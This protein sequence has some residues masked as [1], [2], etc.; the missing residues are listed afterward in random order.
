VAGRYKLAEQVVFRGAA[1][2]GFR[3]PS[4]QQS[5]YSATATNFING[6]PFEVKTAPV[7][8][9]VAR[10]LGSRPLEPEKS[11]NLSAGAAL[12][13]LRG[14]SVTVDY[15]HITIRDRVVLSENFF[16]SPQLLSLLQPL[17]A[18]GARYFTNAID[19]R[20]SGVDVVANSRAA[21][22]PGTVLVTAGY[23]YNRTRAT[24]VAATPAE[25]GNQS[26]TLFGRVERARIE[27]GQPRDNVLGSL[28]YDVR[29]FNATL[30]TQRF[31][32][33]TTRNPRNIATGNVDVPDQ[34]FGARWISDVSLTYRP[35]GR[36][37]ITAGAD[38][39]FDVYPDVNSDFGDPRT[40]RA[41]NATFG[42]LPYN[43]VS[44]FGFN[45]R[46]VYTR[47]SVGF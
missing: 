46:F 6:A 18:S 5:F 26:E 28:G 43:Q 13:P 45:G 35:T 12:S 36:A 47:V 44:P 20:T 24:Q 41:G 33:V 21:V 14:T 39:L 1:A 31:G 34:T 10:A 29:R 38:N 7:N 22:G 32:R 19:T 37:S 42:I 9:P 15:Y 17:G 2:T 11:V 8:S 16:Q 4:L 30:R 3:A 25:L 23:N 27:E 40:G